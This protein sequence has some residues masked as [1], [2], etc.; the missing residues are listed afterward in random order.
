MEAEIRI[1]HWYDTEHRRIACGA[2]GQSNSTK[3]RRG[4][5]CAACRGCIA[6][7][8]APSAAE[9]TAAAWVH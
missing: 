1:V 8:S 4:V 9:G 3:H 6:R 5:T 2:R 7:E